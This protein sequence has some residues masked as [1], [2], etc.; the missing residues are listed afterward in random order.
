LR[1]RGALSGDQQSPGPELFA[2]R[3]PLVVIV[4][5]AAAST[6][7]VCPALD[8]LLALKLDDVNPAERITRPAASIMQRPFNRPGVAISEITDDGNFQAGKESSRLLVVA[9]NFI[10]S[11]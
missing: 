10:V 11:M 4:C 1:H 9:S 8:E 7:R 2:L 3:A 6:C 5:R